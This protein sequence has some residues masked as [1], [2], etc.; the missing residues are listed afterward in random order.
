MNI[1]W[2]IILG[3]VQGFTE[4]LPVSS[5][6]HLVIFQNLIPSITQTGALFYAFLHLGTMTAVLFY[7]RKS[8]ILYISK[9]L[10][11]VAVGT[12]PVYLV[13]LIFRSQIEI[14]FGS[15]K[16]V[17]F[18][19]LVSALF[20]FLTDRGI[21][22]KKK[23]TNGSAL[24]VGVFQALAILPGVS[25]SGATI[26]AG[27]RLGMNKHKAAEF[28]FFLSIPAIIGANL[29]EITVH[30]INGIISPMYYLAGFIAAFISGLVA[31]RLVLK[32]LHLRRFKLFAFYC[33]IV[34]FMILIF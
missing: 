10:M 32:T 34:G 1:F 22:G 25:R 20:N 18:A 3:I 13:G 29:L 21:S 31:I 14:L 16:F 5:S 23:I 30:G 24:W 17:G 2:A 27:S 33:L 4:F 26:F 11:L 9:Y 28:S 12:I 6:G 8:L 7:Y 15:V 19:L